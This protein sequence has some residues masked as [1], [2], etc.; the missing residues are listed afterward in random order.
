V[1]LSALEAQNPWWIDGHVPAAMRDTVPRRLTPSVVTGL[2][3]DLA[4]VVLGPRRVGKTVLVHQVVGRLL[5]G[6]VAPRSV[7]YLSADDPLLGPVATLFEELLAFIEERLLGGSG[8]PIYVLVDEVHVIPDWLLWVKRSIDRRRPLVWLVTSSAGS[9][10]HRGSRESLAGRARDVPLLPFSLAEAAAMVRSPAAPLLERCAEVWESQVIGALAGERAAALR[11]LNDEALGLG[12]ELMRL[13][14]WY[15]RSGGFP[16][17]LAAAGALSPREYFWQTLVE[18]VLY[19]DVPAVARVRQAHVL[20]ELCLRLLSQGPALINIERL[21][22][23][24]GVTHVT[25]AEYLGIIDRTMLDF[26]LPRYA[27]TLAGRQR[28]AKKSVP[29][30]TGLVVALGGWDLGGAQGAVFEGRLAEVV[31]HTWLRRHAAAGDIMHW[32]AR[33]GVEVDFVFAPSGGPVL[34]I[35]VKWGRAQGSHHRGLAEF[36]RRYGEA[37]ALLVVREGLDVSAGQ[38]SLPLWM[39]A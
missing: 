34:P 35:E 24:L 9:I 28:G 8:E 39:L 19:V 32:R 4:T 22:S 2:A 26:I 16:E 6:G 25:V 21:A 11:R 31:V 17:A 27:T 7:V 36:Q 37:E 1:N 38:A 15:L 20:R 5:D 13:S 14:R 33:E 18:R 3:P 10:L 23:E 30:D 29:V 12:D